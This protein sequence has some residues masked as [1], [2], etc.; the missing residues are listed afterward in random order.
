M[1]LSGALDIIAVPLRGIVN[2]LMTISL[3]GVP[4]GAF[5]IGAFI[6]RMILKYV[7]AVETEYTYESISS[8]RKAGKGKG[9]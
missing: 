7:F 4:I 6:V 9:D 2:L 1:T 5:I 8:Q 3:F